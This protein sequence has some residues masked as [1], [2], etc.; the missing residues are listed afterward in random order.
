MQLISIAVFLFGNL[1]TILPIWKN[2]VCE[3]SMEY[4]PDIGKLIRELD[5]D[6]DS[7]VR[8]SFPV[9]AG[10]LARGNLER[11]LIF[12]IESGVSVDT[13]ESVH[14]F[15]RSLYQ[16]KMEGKASVVKAVMLKLQRAAR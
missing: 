6:P 13:S 11:I 3:E 5:E 9:Y 14:R 4:V 7:T 2:N 1:V 15:L 16:I 8:V 12:A 10:A